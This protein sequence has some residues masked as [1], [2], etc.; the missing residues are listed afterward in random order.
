MR[1]FKHASRLLL[2][3]ALALAVAVVGCQSDSPT[4]PSARPTTPQPPTP[5]VTYNITVTAS[6]ADLNV[7]STTPSTV[8]VEVRRSDNGQPPPD[9]TKVTLT[10]TL[11]EFGSIGSGTQSVELQLINGRAQA[12]LFPG[13][14]VGSATLR[15]QLDDSVGGTTVDIRGQQTFFVSS[16]SPNVGAPEGG[17]TVNIDGGGFDE[18]VRVTFNGATAQVISVSPT[19][20]KVRTPSATAAGVTVPVGTSVPVNVSVTV[21]LNE[22]GQAADTLNNGFVYSAG[23]TVEPPR[24][25]S[26]S[27]A[28]GP[29]EGG[30]RV[31]I[32]GSGFQSPVQVIFGLG[33]SVTSFNGV[34]AQVESVEPGRIVVLT[35]SARAFGQN[36]L[37][38]VVDVLVKNL[39][40]GFS[41]ISPQAFKYGTN[42]LITGMGPGSGPYTGGT[43]VT[44][45]GQGFDDPVAVSLGGVG[46]QVLSVSGTQIVFRTV[47]VVVNS[48][49]A[50]GVITA[51]GVSVTNLDT[52]DSATAGNLSF[53]YLVPRPQIFGINP[54]S[55]NPG[56]N[57]TITG[58]NFAANVQ[59]L[60][61]D[62]ANGSSAPIN[63]NN[64]TTISVRVPQAP[65]GFTFNTEPC[66][67]NGD[68]I[69]G[70][71]RNAPTAISVTVRNLDGTGCSVTLPNAYLL[72]PP[73]TTCTGD[74]SAPPPTTAQCNDG[75]DND[76]DG[77]IDFGAGPTND[78]QCT[79]LDDNSEAL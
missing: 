43:Q 5:T 33:G 25:F 49:P 69:P 57:A 1:T 62:A 6:P 19:R 24:V 75:I 34:E 53:Q 64:A 77:R 28:S 13:G 27:P 51:T 38:A 2:A 41:T 70:G 14:A 71:T 50:N 72:N 37:N 68:G 15:A 26:V 12:A 63:S 66:D 20:I 4:E 17:Q 52:G 48:C 36:L 30:T 7:G 22:N 42:V 31:T 32:V 16:I 79:S 58:T 61:G 40:S 73:N 46:Q 10:T 45:T 76:G 29:N 59:V 55:G 67:G 21:N 60:F 56:N 65:A 39:N 78:P 44:I 54:T 74:T 3:L 47:G 8:T 9:L 11:G 35:P 18:P 23:G